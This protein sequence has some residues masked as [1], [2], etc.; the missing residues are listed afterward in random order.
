[1]TKTR[2]GAARVAHGLATAFVT[3]FATAGI[4]L[5]AVALFART[6]GSGVTR[7]AGHPVMTVLSD[8]MTPT[9][10]AGD[11]IIEDPVSNADQLEVGDAITFRAGGSGELVTHRI[12]RVKGSPT[13]GTVQYRTQGDANNALD[14]T[15]VEPEQV[16]GLYSWRIPF[17]GYALQAA[18]SQAGMFLL[19]FIPGALLLL[20][21]LSRWW[22]SA[23]EAESTAEEPM[24]QATE[25]SDLV[26]SDARK[27][28]G[29]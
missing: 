4:L 22:R 5:L 7:V 6:D 25:D 9:F 10:K 14:L 13:D 18:Q 3:V 11:L 27:G 19:F 17:A 12:V 26:P 1:M 8:S 23:G 29:G 24:T 28:A 16:V 15:P 21:V 20:P 2:T